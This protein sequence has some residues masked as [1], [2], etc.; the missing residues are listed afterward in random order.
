MCANPHKKQDD[1]PLRGSWKLND[2]PLTKGSKTDDPP[3][4]CSGPLPILFDQSLRS[5][6][7]IALRIPT[8]HNFMCD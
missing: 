4:I 2:P 6:P 1:P 8:A 7:S 3:P 5:F